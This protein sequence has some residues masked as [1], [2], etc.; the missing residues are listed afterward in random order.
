M[1]RTRLSILGLIVA[2]LV[3]CTCIATAEDAIRLSRTAVEQTTYVSSDRDL[4]GQDLSE[5]YIQLIGYSEAAGNNQWTLTQTS[6]P[7]DILRIEGNRTTGSGVWIEFAKSV[8]AAGNYTYTLTCVW[9]GVTYEAQYTLHIIEIEPLRGI[10]RRDAIYMHV[11]DV[12]E[13][14]VVLNPVDWSIPEAS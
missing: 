9:Q 10:T 8:P 5:G 14:E 12:V 6:G 4:N 11:G 3:C 2:I 7:E 13:D 1:Q